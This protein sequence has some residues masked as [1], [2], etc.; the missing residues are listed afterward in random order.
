MDGE[1][2]REI[3]IEACGVVG[4]EMRLEWRVVDSTGDFVA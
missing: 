1:V 3:E 4:C 2:E